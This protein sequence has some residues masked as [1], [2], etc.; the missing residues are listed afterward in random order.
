MGLKIVIIALLSAPVFAQDS[1]YVRHFKDKLSVQMFALNTYNRFNVYYI[2]ENLRVDI[3]PNQKTTLNIGMQ[4][5]IASFSFGFAPS[6]FAR[7]RDNQ[8]SKIL[9]FSTVVYPGRFMQV[10]E[11]Y[12]Q[13]GMSLV[14]E[15]PYVSIYLPQFR[16]IKIGGSTSFLFNRHFSYRAVSLQNAKQLRSQGSFSP[17]IFYYY[18][19]LDGRKDPSLG[20]RSNFL[21]VAA[22]MAY[23]YNWVIA[24]D[25]LLASGTSIGAGVSWADDGDDSYTASL[26]KAS[27]MLAPGYNSERWFGGAQFRIHAG[28]HESKSTVEIS[29][30]IGYVTAFIGYRF[31]APPFLERQKY[32]IKNKLKI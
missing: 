15:T 19:S 18:T 30:T 27:F 32:R 21:D 23:Y 2:N 10:M 25:F 28:G 12:Y 9:S 7:N 26:Y 11:F 29:D 16:S 22:E 8:D 24:K 4:Y 20:S 13:K 17:G 31:D 14:N 5:D 3:I 6:F 1:T